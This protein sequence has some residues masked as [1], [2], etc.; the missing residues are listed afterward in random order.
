MKKQ[1][2]ESKKNISHNFIVV[3][4]NILYVIFVLLI[5][6]TGITEAPTILEKIKYIGIAIILLI[7][8]V[9]YF[10]AR[11]KN[12]SKL[13][14]L[15]IVYVLGLIIIIIIWTIFAWPA[16]KDSLPNEKECEYVTENGEIKKGPCW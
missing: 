15:S 2:L 13:H 6:G 14:K 11:K 16:I 9:I 7:P 3:I 8:I 12:S 5:C 10:I 4:A 1:E